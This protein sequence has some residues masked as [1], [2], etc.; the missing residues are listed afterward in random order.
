MVSKQNNEHMKGGLVETMRNRVRVSVLKS[1]SRILF[2]KEKK[3]T[4]ILGAKT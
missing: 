4:L 2:K 1:L 3:K